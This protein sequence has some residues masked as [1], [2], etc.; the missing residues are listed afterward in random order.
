MLS[1]CKIERSQVKFFSID[2]FV[3]QDH[4]LEK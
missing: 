1:K 4:L 3:I 2:D